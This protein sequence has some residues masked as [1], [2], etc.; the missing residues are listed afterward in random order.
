MPRK[1]RIKS[2]SGIYHIMLRG[3]NKQMIFLDNEDYKKFLC[4]IKECKAV[5]E[6]E[7]FAYCL[8]GNHIHL[9]IK[10]GRERIDL[11]FKRIG[12]R[13]VYWYNKKYSRCGHLFQDRFLSEAIESDAYFITVFNYIHQN[14][15]E[16]GLCKSINEYKWS[17]YFDYI[18]KNGMTD[19][20]FAIS[21]IGNKSIETLFNKDESIK[22]KENFDGKIKLSDIEAIRLIEN[23]LK[24]KLDMIPLEPRDKMKNILRNALNIEG[25]STR[26][27]SRIT[28]VSK[29]KIWAL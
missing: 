2:S 25:I 12:S 1:A 21:L 29:N 16:A 19:I 22:L 7:L 6:F 8:M 13:F 3:I 10:E 15:L 17:S 5:C 27:L 24:I 4:I 20:D 23:T 28:G 11:I 18:N 26:Q 9:L 14:P